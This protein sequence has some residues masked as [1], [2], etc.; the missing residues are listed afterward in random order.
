[1]KQWYKSKTI[2]G[3]AISLLP[4]ILQVAGIPLPIG[5]ALNEAIIAAGGGLAIVGRIQAKDKLSLK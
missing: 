4:T 1:V 2:W 3:I 5:A